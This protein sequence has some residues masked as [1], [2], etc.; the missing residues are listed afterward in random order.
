MFKLL[1]AA[2]AILT[3]YAPTHNTEQ[4]SQDEEYDVQITG[5]LNNEDEIEDTDD[6]EDEFLKM[7]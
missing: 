1:L 2:G 6:T 5:I 7:V 4:Q 3:V